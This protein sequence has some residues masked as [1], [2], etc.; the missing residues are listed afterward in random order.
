MN[1]KKAILKLVENGLLKSLV[2]D[3]RTIQSLGNLVSPQSQF[4]TLPRP[5]PNSVS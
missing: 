2:C 3:V 5:A 4:L 1:R